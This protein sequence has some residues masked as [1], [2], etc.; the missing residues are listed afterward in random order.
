MVQNRKTN[1]N[2]TQ[3][4]NIRRVYIRSSCIQNKH[5]AQALISLF[6]LVS[7]LDLQLALFNLIT[8]SRAHTFTKDLR[9]RLRHLVR[10]LF[11]KAQKKSIQIIQ[12]HLLV[13]ARLAVFSAS[14]IL[15]LHSKRGALFNLFD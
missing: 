12:G 1:T 6:V 2:H 11:Y 7:K 10:H 8:P 13:G 3:K 15:H 5:R 14:K 9:L 4:L